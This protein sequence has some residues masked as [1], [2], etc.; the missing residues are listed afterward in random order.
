M[1]LYKKSPTVARN[2]DSGAASSTS[3]DALST[4]VSSSDVSSPLSDKLSPPSPIGGA[5]PANSFLRVQPTRASSTVPVD[6]RMS[7]DIGMILNGAIQAQT[8]NSSFYASA[9]DSASSSQASSSDI[10]AS[11]VDLVSDKP[12]LAPV[13][14]LLCF[15]KTTTKKNFFL[16]IATTAFWSFLR[17]QGAVLV[18]RDND[19]G[20]L[21]KNV[22][23]VVQGVPQTY[24][25]RICAI[26]SQPGT[27][28]KG[29]LF[30]CLQDC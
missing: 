6:T 19:P 29:H 15:I 9:S 16:H 26:R 21:F 20:L 8:G 30:D 11:R 7:A 28:Q 4:S 14:V 12:N 25:A 24:C 22:R 5:R 27:I 18:E 2:V 3:N 10:S 23:L 13:N 17:S 1:Q